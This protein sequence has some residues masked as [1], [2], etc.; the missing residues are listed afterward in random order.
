MASRSVSLHLVRPSSLSVVVVLIILSL[1][2]QPALA[3]S[4]FADALEILV[5][6]LQSSV[7]FLCIIV[8]S[9]ALEFIVGK[10]DFMT[11]KYLKVALSLFMEEVM[12]IGFVE[13]CLLTVRSAISNIGETMELEFN[14]VALTLVFMALL[15]GIISSALA[16][17]LQSKGRDWRN[18]EWGRL[19]A[20]AQHST[21]E[22]LFNGVDLSLSARINSFGKCNRLLFWWDMEQP[23][24][25]PFSHSS[26][27]LKR[28]LKEAITAHQAVDAVV[29]ARVT[30]LPADGALAF[31]SFGATL[32]LYKVFHLIMMWYLAMY[33]VVEAKLS[34]DGHGWYCILVAV[35]ALIPVVVFYVRYP[36]SVFVPLIAVALGRHVNEDAIEGLKKG[37]NLDDSSSEDDDI[38]EDER[39]EK[40]AAAAGA[41]QRMDAVRMGPAVSR[42]L[43]SSSMAT[44]INQQ[45]GTI[46]LRHDDDDERIPCDDEVDDDFGTFHDGVPEDQAPPPGEPPRVMGV[47]PTNAMQKRKW[48]VKTLEPVFL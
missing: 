9:V 42:P 19:E 32:Q 3:D 15:F 44:A 33:V 30:Q 8:S 10:V 13:V 4:I 17:K 35:E 41:T 5:N 22:G 21:V 14:V 11:N 26:R 34:Y 38:D 46:R 25:R 36:T 31:N 18:F 47:P 20:D 24:R 48:N 2:S 28:F 6:P 40:I 23:L 39:C 12:V 45:G 37:C 16:V 27:R 43:P 1:C 7:I 29:D